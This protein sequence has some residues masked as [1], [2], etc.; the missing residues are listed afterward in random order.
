MKFAN[1]KMTNWTLSLYVKYYKDLGTKP[2]LLLSIEEIT[3]ENESAWTGPQPWLAMLA[4]SGAPSQPRSL[5][6]SN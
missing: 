1:Q 4:L 2:L 3:S 6:S 5:L